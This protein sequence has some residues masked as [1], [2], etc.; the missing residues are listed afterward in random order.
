MKTI[1]SILGI[2]LF[3][4]ALTPKSSA[5]LSA[6]RITQK[7]VNANAAENQA[8]KKAL[9]DPG[10]TTSQP[11]AGGVAPA[12]PPQRVITPVVPE[13]TPEQK[14]KL[15]QK[16]IEFQKKRAEAGSP[17]SQYDLGMRYLNGDG[18]EKN[19]EL[20]KKWLKAAATNGN[21]QAVKQLEE[22]DKK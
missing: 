9:K 7:A 1:L 5:Q 16:T 17:T 14:A 8:L 4:F 10:S 11:P 2:G 12:N 13:K 20:A 21:S 15:L 22:L 6:R 3:V 19:P 18:L